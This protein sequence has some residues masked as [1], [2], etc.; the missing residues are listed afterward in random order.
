MQDTKKP[1]EP[2]E[3]FIDG[4]YTIE[5]KGGEVVYIKRGHTVMKPV[6]VDSPR[7]H[8]PREPIKLHKNLKQ[9]CVSLGWLIDGAKEGDVCRWVW[10]KWY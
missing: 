3:A 1:Q 5:V 9:G 4:I 8:N 6:E 2:K 7:E 10:G